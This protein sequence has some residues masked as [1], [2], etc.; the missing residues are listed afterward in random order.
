M[1][2]FSQVIL[3]FFLLLFFSLSFG[4]KINSIKIKGNKYVSDEL[5]KELLITKEGSD[6]SLERIRE[7]IRRLFKTGFFRKI[8]VHK[9]EEE[10]GISILFIVEDLPVIYKIEFEGNDELSDTDLADKLGIETEVGK[11]DVDELITGYT[12]SPALEE[13]LEIQRK[14][15]LGRVLSQ[16]EIDALVRRIKEIYREEGYPEVEVSY[17]I[18]PKKGAS[19]LVFLIKEGEERYVVDIVFK[20]NKTFTKG[21]LK[22]LMETEDRNIFVLRLKP[23]FSEEILKD[24]IE[25]IKDFYKREGFL[26]VKVNYEVKRRNG[27]HDI[28]IY[29]EEGE[30]YKLKALKIKGNTLYAYSE[31]VGDILEKNKRKGGYY[32]LDVIER[33]ERNIRDLY[34]EIGF[35]NLLIEREVKVDAERKEITVVLK[36]R[37]GEPVYVRKV[38][39][40]GNYETRDYVIRRELRVQEHGLVIKKG[41]RRSKSRIMNLGYY[42]DVQIQPFPVDGE[43]WDLLVKIRERFTGQFSVG[44]SYNEITKLSAFIS[45]RKGNFLGTGDIVGLSVSYGSQYKDNSVSYTDKWFLGMPVDLTWSVF[46]R[47]I[48]YTTYTVERTGLSTTFSREFWEYWRWSVGASFQRIKYSDISPTASA[49][50]RNQEGVRESR[51][52]I[53]SIS[54][55]SRDY[56]LFPTEGSYFKLS[57][58]VAV[59]VLGG[60]ER[61]HKVSWTGSKFL[62]DTYFD[63]GL[64][65]SSKLTVGFVEPYGNEQVPLDERFFVGGDFTIRGYRYGMAGVVDRNGDPIGS[66]K[67]LIMNFEL[68]YKLHKILYL[69]AFYDTGLG[70]NRWQEFYPNNWRGGYGIGIRFVTPLAPIRLDWAWK[71]KK[72]RGDRA[73][74]RFHFVIGGFF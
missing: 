24:D 57:Y 40:E 33:L 38:K 26:E 35:I 14:L 59:P 10:K 7:D 3:P 23:P 21:K 39:I 9:L 20:G 50:I 45:L 65:F 11:I 47:R 63:T 27:R 55:D 8:E 30:R 29:V 22:E 36:L 70:A 15:K 52:F 73:N 44:L 61:F 5:I 43:R 69:A 58:A 62:K 18:V 19:K 6:F 49:F 71:T 17:K 34:A 2:R 56:F 68:S 13:R 31:L 72:V 1:I 41:L 60:T 54:R 66:T 48:E 74:S 4:E 25:K 42:E 28:F 32:R 16:K 37:E 53:F 46:D 12:S 64:V 51:K 67:E